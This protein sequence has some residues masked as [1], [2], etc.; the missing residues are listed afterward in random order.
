MNF[1]SILF[2]LFLFFDSLISVTILV[3]DCAGLQNM[4]GELNAN[5]V[6]GK[7]L[8]CSSGFVPVGDSAAPFTGSL[9]G[10]GYSLILNIQIGNIETGLFG[11]GSNCTVSN[12]LIKNS[13]LTSDKGK[14]GILFGSLY[15]SSISNIQVSTENPIMKNN[16]TS[17]GGYSIGGLVK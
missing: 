2:L 16:L 9:D 5:F 15:N 14:L 17:N 3:N 12:L 1:F 11:V 10:Q 4:N 8:D 7:D 6:I 13:N